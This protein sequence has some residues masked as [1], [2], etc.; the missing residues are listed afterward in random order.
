MERSCRINGILK[1]IVA[2]VAAGPKWPTLTS[3]AMS[4]HSSCI[5]KMTGENNCHHALST[6][7]T[8]VEVRHVVAEE[9]IG[10]AIGGAGLVES[11]PELQVVAHWGDPIHGYVVRVA[12]ALARRLGC[13]RHG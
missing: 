6:I 1:L 4:I 11:Q 2:K 3:N 12:C 7:L 10:E 8:A 13:P 5:F 9:D